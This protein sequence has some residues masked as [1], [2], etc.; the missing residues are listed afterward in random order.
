MSYIRRLES[1]SISGTNDTICCAIRCCISFLPYQF[2]IFDDVGRLTALKVR[3]TINQR[4][5]VCWDVYKLIRLVA[6]QRVIV[7]K[8]IAGVHSF[9]NE[10]LDDS[11][12]NNII[13]NLI[14][15]VYK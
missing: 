9:L 12:A 8:N 3:L 6:I 2:S 14:F 4:F 13:K 7:S 5:V 15:F 10:T 11:Q 1:T